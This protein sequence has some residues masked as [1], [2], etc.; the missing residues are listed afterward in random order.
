M[1]LSQTRGVIRIESEIRNGGVFYHRRALLSSTE[2][3]I[4]F[5][6][7]GDDIVRI[8][9]VPRPLLVICVVFGLALAYRLVRLISIGDV[10]AYAMLASITVFAF[11]VF[12][13]WMHSPRE[14]GYLTNSGGLLFVD[15]T[16]RHDPTSYLEEIQ[17]AKIAHIR[18]LDDGETKDVTESGSNQTLLH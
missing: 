16:G 8:F 17:R 2:L 12:M 3:T 18:R 13:A 14:V 4:P 9:H 1:K 11:S 10:S 5:E 6:H 7:I 15:A